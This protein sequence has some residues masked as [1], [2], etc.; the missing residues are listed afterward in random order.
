MGKILS[1]QSVVVCR[2]RRVVGKMVSSVSIFEII[3]VGVRSS[4]IYVTPLCFGPQALVLFTVVGF[5]ALCAAQNQ[6]LLSQNGFNNNPA[7]PPGR[8]VIG[9]PGAQTPFNSNNQ[10]G[11]NNGQPNNF[12]FG[13]GG[14]IGPQPPADGSF[15]TSNGPTGSGSFQGPN[16]GWSYNYGSYGS[17]ASGIIPKLMM[18]VWAVLLICVF[19]GAAKHV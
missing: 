7:A 14:F 3:V 6:P 15:Q 5:I 16:G 18:T 19:S 2:S 1:A 10:P 9:A 8:F 4:F 11:F 13:Q 12:E 17:S